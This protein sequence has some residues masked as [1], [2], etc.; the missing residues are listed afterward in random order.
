MMWADPGVSPIAAGETV[1]VPLLM[2]TPVVVGETH[3][4]SIFVLGEVVVV[5]EGST[6]NLQEVSVAT[7]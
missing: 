1:V 3:T 4:I 7:G 5:A 2:E 6:L